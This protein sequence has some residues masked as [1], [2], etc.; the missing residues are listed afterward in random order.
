MYVRK[1]IFR[2]GDRGYDGARFFSL[3]VRLTTVFCLPANVAWTAANAADEARSA[4]QQVLALI[5]ASKMEDVAIIRF[6]SS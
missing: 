3:S 5:S 2:I 1:H 6:A 4:N